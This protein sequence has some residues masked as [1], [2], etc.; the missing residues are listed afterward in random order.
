M[1]TEHPGSPNLQWSIRASGDLGRAIAGIRR[2]REWTQDR[3]AEE[4]GVARPYISR[5]EA[6][7]ATLAL[8]RALLAL[9]RLGAEVT[10]SLRDEDGAP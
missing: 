9:R 1:H 10:V 4:M 7:H 3:L 5:L 6:G 8:E 2:Q